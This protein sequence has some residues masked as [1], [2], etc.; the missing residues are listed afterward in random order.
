MQLK[1]SLTTVIVEAKKNS[2]EQR[3]YFQQEAREMVDKWHQNSLRIFEALQF[4]ISELLFNDCCTER[5]DI[6]IEKPVTE[7]KKIDPSMPCMLNNKSFKMK[8][9]FKFQINFVHFSFGII[10]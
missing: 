9:M 4:R 7:M 6:A 2:D 10:E 3:Q 8:R 5:R 1:S